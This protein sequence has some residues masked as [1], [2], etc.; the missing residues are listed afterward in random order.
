MKLTYYLTLYK[1]ASMRITL[2]IKMEEIK[3]KKKYSNLLSGIFLSQPL[4]M[5]PRKIILY[6]LPTLLVTQLCITK[7]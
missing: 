2:H 5:R 4:Q 6:K 1:Y 3:L 7:E